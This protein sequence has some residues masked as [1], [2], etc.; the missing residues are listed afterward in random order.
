MAKTTSR[1]EGI[2]G[3]DQRLYP[4]PYTMRNLNMVRLDQNGG[5]TNDVGW[6]P[7]VNID[8]PEIGNV[9]IESGTL[10]TFD[11]APCR[12]LGIWSRHQNA[13]VYYLHEVEGRLQYYW[14]NFGALEY[15]DAQVVLDSDRPEP[16]SD[17]CGTQL[18]P[19]GR[20][21]LLVNGASAP[22]KFWGRA[23]TEGF[24]W[25]SP[26]SPPTVLT[27]Q[28]SALNASF[29]SAGSTCIRI[30]SASSLFGVGDGANKNTNT[31]AYRYAWISNTGSISPPSAPTF[32]SWSIENTSEAGK[33]GVMLR[34]LATGPEGTVA[35]VIYRT[36]NLRDS[37]SVNLLET[38]Y[39]VARIE[40]NYLPQWIDH[41][42]DSMLSAAPVDLQAS[43]P[44]DTAYKVGCEFDGRL[45]LAGGSA[46]PTR[47]IWSEAG[48]PEQF[49]L[50]S[51]FELGSRVGGKV[52][53]LV[54]YYNALLVFRNAAVDV[55]TK[56]SS[57]QYQVSTLDS[58][59]G[60]D[61]TN[62]IK[63]VPGVGVMFLTKEGVY[64]VTGGLYGGSTLRVEA[65]GAPL[66]EE[67]KRL[68]LAAL[69]RASATYSPKEQEYWV[70]YCVDGNTD[71]S[72]GAVYHLQSGGW[73]LRHGDGPR[74]LAFTQLATDPWGWIILGTN[75]AGRPAEWTDLENSDFFPGWGL[76]VWSYG[77][78]WGTSF[79]IAVNPLTETT[80][81]NAWN[82]APAGESTWTSQWE[83]LSDLDL[84][85]A[86]VRVKA[87]GL[88]RGDYEI[89]L[90]WS[91]DYGYE[92]TA[93]TT[94][95]GAIDAK[96]YGGPSAQR[97][98][99]TVTP[100]AP[101][102]YAIWDTSRWEGPRRMVYRWD[103]GAPKASTMKWEVKTSRA[104]HLLRYSV[105]SM[106]SAT[107]TPNSRG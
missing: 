50:G 91:T 4:E 25:S 16:K 102:G 65:I 81:M 88:S 8:T 80:F 32:V 29:V 79:T 43:V 22:I 76:Q 15:R 84:Q 52:S 74:G 99:G 93:V 77:R 73:S 6:E 57:G 2:R 17:D 30:G 10:D 5:W 49:A 58:S 18:I 26:P 72:R 86:G 89:P 69:A 21:A 62:S 23:R 24:G 97:V 82:P 94:G 95:A 39:E 96:T 36:K 63:E 71:C 55:I 46:H 61:A 106:V 66:S 28:P 60:T 31:Y 13:E 7:Q 67:W 35:H 54:P 70:T 100:P 90:S 11:F 105:E 75:P 48:A 20:F 27:P 33:Q 38:F 83:D 40:G 1:T 107:R 53:A 12:F 14:G 9:V 68:S 34:D 101:R 37:T 64:V 45:W 3:V 42:P 51:Y 87:E 78:S 59:I 92:Q 103:L 85:K 41:L 19:Y 56:L 98:F 104:W 44:I 47:I